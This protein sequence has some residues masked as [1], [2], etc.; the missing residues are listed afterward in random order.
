MSDKWES[1]IVWTHALE[2]ENATLRK[3]LDVANDLLVRLEI[4]SNLQK[5]IYES[6]LHAFKAIHEEVIKAQAIIEYFGRGSE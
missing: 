6:P 3:Q 4:A 2:K 1:G 5:S